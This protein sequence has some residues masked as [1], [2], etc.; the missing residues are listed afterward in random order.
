MSLA[1][2]VMGDRT[3]HGGTVITADLTFT[4]HGKSVARVGDFTVCPKC[5]GTFPIKTGAL[6]LVDGEGRGYAR[7]MDET[8][9]GARLV[10]SQITTTWDNH[11]SVGTPEVLEASGGDIAAPGNSG[12]CLECLITASLAG[13]ATIIR[14]R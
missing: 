7:H 10:S 8:A 5:K 14:Q 4:I 13:S 9:C 3:T 6:D 12:I 2:I 1:L 11:T